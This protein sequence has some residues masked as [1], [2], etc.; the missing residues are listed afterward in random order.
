VL[1][2]AGTSSTNWIIPKTV[3]EHQSHTLVAGWIAGRLDQ[4]KRNQDGA[5]PDMTD[6]GTSGRSRKDILVSCL[7]TGLLSYWLLSLLTCLR[8]E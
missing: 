3:P 8:T 6:T 5:V 7:S 4:G 1:L 2:Y